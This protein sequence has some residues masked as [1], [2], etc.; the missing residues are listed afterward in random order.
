[1][2]EQIKTLVAEIKTE[3][4]KANAARAKLRKSFNPD[5]SN[6]QY[7][8]LGAWALA[9]FG[10]PMPPGYWIAQDKYWRNIITPEGA[11]PYRASDPRSTY[12][13]MSAAGLATLFIT[14]EFL[15][16]SPRLDTVM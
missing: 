10:I 11:F 3:R 2:Q 16:T 14:Q 6:T 1:M 9:D 7:G 13:T 12:S 15:D 4:T 5:G 8:V